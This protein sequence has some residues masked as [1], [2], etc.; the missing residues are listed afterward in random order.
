MA[1]IRPAVH[2]VLAAGAFLGAW[3]LWM[4][5]G[6]VFVFRNDESWLS[7]FAV[8]LG[9]GLT[10]PAVVTAIIRPRVAGFVLLAGACLSSVAL[11]AGDGPQFST[12][13]PFLIRVALPMAVLGAV[14]LALSQ[15]TPKHVPSVHRS[16][17]A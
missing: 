4:A 2:F 12:V 10:L 16:N 3:H 1:R 5:A 7:W 17:A 13:V 6:A 9:P 14:L 11:T 15:S 8:L